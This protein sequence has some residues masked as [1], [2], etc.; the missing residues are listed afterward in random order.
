MLAAEDYT[1]VS[2]VPARA[3]AAQVRRRLRRR[4]RPPPAT[5]PTS[6]TSTRTAARRRDPL[7]VLS[8]YKAVVWYTGDDI[9]T[10]DAGQPGGTGTAQARAGRRA[11]AVRDY[12]NEG[13]KL[14]SPARTPRT[15]S[16]PAFPYSP[17]RRAAVLQR[18][19][20]DHADARPPAAAAVSTTSCSTGWAPTA[21]STRRLDDDGDSALPFIGAAGRSTAPSFTLNGADRADNQDHTHSF[22]DHVELPAARRSSRSSPARR[23]A[24]PGGGRST[25]RPA[26][27]TSTSHERRRRLQA[28]DPDGRPDRPTGA[29]TCRS[30]LL[31]HR[32]GLGLHVRRGPHRRARTTG[33]RCRTPTAHTPDDVGGCRATQ[34]G[35]APPVPRPLPDEHDKARPP[36]TRT[37][38][39]PARPARGTRRPATPAAGR[40]GRST[41]RLRRQAGRGVDHLRSG[42]GDAGL[43]VFLDDAEGDGRRRD[44]QRDLVRGRPRRL[45]AA[46]PPAA[47]RAER[48]G[49]SPGAGALVEGRAVATRDTL[50]YGFGLEG[51]RG[52][53]IRQREVMKSAMQYLGV[54]KQGGVAARPG[55]GGS[56]GRQAGDTTRSA[57]PRTGPVEDKH[58]RTQ[59][60]AHLKGG[61]KQLCRGTVTL[62]R[63]K[64]AMGRKSFTG[65]GPTKPERHGP[66]QEVRLQAP[67]AQG[68]DPDDDHGRD[69]R[70]PTACC[71]R[72]RRGAL[73]VRKAAKKAKKKQ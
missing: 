59:G 72:S 57:S 68:Q 17:A 63:G 20:C 15:R 33:P 13:G 45:D 44:G 50:Y 32:A 8:H 56:G 1:G 10:R 21:T 46:G 16:S 52:A 5:A 24:R 22:A 70:G 12:L 51:V 41:C 25:R 28:A 31:R 38:R 67:Q 61:I 48:N 55:G 7:G 27:G 29:A 11:V 43:G 9:I 66:D 23:L 19:R 30:S 18:R 65:A 60:A 53:S 3:P 69:S 34:L 54:L 36:A 42:L 39:R 2:P 49:W 73:M 37:A 4:A 14:L 47:P 26:T 6:T 64:K 35:H 40:T 71:G 62:R 58:R